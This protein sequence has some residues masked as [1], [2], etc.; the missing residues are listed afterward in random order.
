MQLPH[1]HKIK[2]DK[3]GNQSNKHECKYIW[4]HPEHKCEYLEVHVDESA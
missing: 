3:K 1:H 4:P 2:P